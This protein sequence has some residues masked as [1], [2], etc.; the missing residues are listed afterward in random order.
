M[1]IKQIVRIFVISL[2][3]L[4][5]GA[6]SHRHAGMDESGM[7]GSGGGQEGVQATGIGENENYGGAG[8][9]GMSG[10]QLLSKRTYYFDFDRSEVHE[11]DKPA[12]FANA[13]YLVS[14]PRMK[15]IVEGHTDPRGS[16]EY[17][18]A[19]AERRA[20][21]VADLL[22]SR[23]VRPNQIRVVSYGAERLAVPGH[24]EQDY[25]LDRRAI[26]VYQ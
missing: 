12:I 15:V 8:G 21:T 2:A 1:L 26:I 3:L 14:H 5:L 25:Q 18:V 7:G 13:N 4:A 23:G 10:H 9:R 11:S 17:N 16:R 6:C 24:T 20:N 19:L 22:K